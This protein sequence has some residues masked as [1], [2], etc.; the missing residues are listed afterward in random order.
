MDK[1]ARYIDD[2]LR[3][4]AFFLQYANVIEEHFPRNTKKILMDLPVKWDENFVLINGKKP[5]EVTE[6]DY[7][8]SIGARAKLPKELLIKGEIK[9]RPFTFKVKYG[10]NSHNYYIDFEDGA[11]IGS[12]TQIRSLSKIKDYLEKID[13]GEEHSDKDL[14]KLYEDIFKGKAKYNKLKDG[15]ISKFFND[16]SHLNW[17]MVPR[18]DKQRGEVIKV[19][20]YATDA[21]PEEYSQVFKMMAE[22]NPARARHQLTDLMKLKIPAYVGNFLEDAGYKEDISIKGLMKPTIDDEDESLSGKL[23]FTI[24]IE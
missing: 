24:T 2:E 5:N 7:I 4:I 1:L 21:N 22:S 18:K 20:L 15:I 23:G 3:R 10:D 11:S 8:E 17:R 6:D 14:S 13:A 19:P 12:K 16:Y 9:E